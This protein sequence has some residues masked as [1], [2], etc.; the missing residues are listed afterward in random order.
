MDLQLAGKTAI[1]A[2]GSRGIGKACARQLALEGV[3]VAIAARTREALDEAA[4][5]IAKETG[6][7]IVP[8]VCDTTDDESVKS[9]VQQA[10]AALGR[11]DI[12]VNSAAQVSGFEPA[13]KLDQVNDDNFWNDMNT[14]VMGALRCAREVAPYMRQNH[15]GRIINIS[16]LGARNAGSILG[17]IRNVSLVALTKNLADQ[18]GADGINVTVVHP[19]TTKTEKREEWFRQEA[20]RRG[21]TEAELEKQFA[22]NSVRKM[23]TAEE[24]G[25]IVAFLASPKSVAISGD[26]IAAGG[27][28]GRAIYY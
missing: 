13:P 9:M 17:S 3:D 2:G 28:D 24:I 8:I 23:I 12:L 18:L 15:W 22:N 20:Q 7:K 6:R 5:E 27:G 4:A 11:V 21:V 10:V 1:V 19:G 16:G 26:V 25:Y 14:K